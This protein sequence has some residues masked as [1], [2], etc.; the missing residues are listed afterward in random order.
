M[1]SVLALINIRFLTPVT[2]II[3]MVDYLWFTYSKD[4]SQSSVLILE[5]LVLI[6]I[7]L[8]IYKLK[9]NK[10]KIIQLFLRHL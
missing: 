8:C 5:N 6:L 10:K 7:L 1:P 9:A 2:S 3:F 4:H